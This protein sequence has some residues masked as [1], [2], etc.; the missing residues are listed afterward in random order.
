MYIVHLKHP[1]KLH[2][3]GARGVWI[4]DT[5]YQNHTLD[6]SSETEVPTTFTAQYSQPGHFGLLFVSQERDEIL[7]YI[8]FSLSLRCMHNICYLHLMCYILA[9][10]VH[11]ELTVYMQ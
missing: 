10:K 9:I 8:T 7:A 5:C 3:T 4:T 1:Y 11:E 6:N 2:P